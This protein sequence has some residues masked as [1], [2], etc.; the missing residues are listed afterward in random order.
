MISI[1][2]MYLAGKLRLEDLVSDRLRID[3]IILRRATLR[4]ARRPN[5]QWNVKALLPLPALSEKP[6]VLTIDDAT[7][8]VNDTSHEESAAQTV[9]GIALKL[10]PA[11]KEPG[12]ADAE[13]RF[14]VVGSATGLPARELRVE[15]DICTTDGK[16]DLTVKIADLEVSSEL[17]AA[18]P[19][20]LTAELRGAEVSGR[21]DVTLQM[22][23][24]ASNEALNWF[25][26]AK[27]DRGRIAHPMLPVPLTDLV[28][29]CRADARRLLVEHL[30]A[31]CGP[32][33]MVL[34]GE[35][36]TWAKNAPLALAAQFIGLPLN[37]DLRR[38]LPEPCARVWQRFQPA[39]TIDAEIRVTFD[40]RVWRPQLTA[41][42]RA[43]SLTDAEKF[44]YRLEQTTGRVEYLPAQADRA[45]SLRLD[46]T[47][48][49]GGRPVRLAAELSH[50]V[51]SEPEEVSPAQ[52]AKSLGPSHPLG[53][54]EISGSDIPLHEELF[55][56]LSEKRE[57]L[58]RSLQPQG[59]IDFRFRA[60]W[61]E[62][63]QLRAEINQEIRLK[64]C[65]IRYEPFPFPL[66]HVNGLVTQQERRW[67]I[68]DVE[69]RGGN[70][71]TIVK[72]RG[73]STPRGD[74]LHTDLTIE[75]TSVSLDDNL[76]MALSPA[77]QQA[78]DE[79]RPQGRV[80]F[81]ARV[82]HDTD[83]PEPVIE[84]RIQPR[85]RSV[86]IEPTKLPYRLDQI[87]GLA[88]YSA[89]QV[90]L[91]NVSGRHDRAAYSATAGTWKPL[92]DGGWQLALGGVNAD[93]L[94]PRDLLVALPPTLQRT[95]ERMQPGGTF[96]VYNSSL[97][98]IKNR[99]SQ[100][101]AAAWDVNLVCHQATLRGGPPLQN[102]TGE[103]RLV[104]RDDGQTLHTAGE[105]ALDSIVWKD[106]Q[107]TNVRGPLWIDSAVCL[108]GEPASKKQ[109]QSPR[110]ITA[111]AYG[112]SVAANVELQH[113]SAQSYNLD[114]A[115]GGANLA[116]F[117]NERLSGLKD[118]SGTVSGRLAVSGNGQ[119][120][121]SLRGTGDLH[122]VEANIYE[123]PVL[124]AMLKVLKIRAPDTTAFNRCDMQFTID[125]E[126]IHFQQLNLLGDAVSLYGKGESGFDRRLDLTFYTL[127]EP[128][129]LPIPLWK[130]IAGQVSKQTL[131]LKVG[132]T[133]D[134]ADVQPQTLPAV[135][136]VWEQIQTEIQAGAASMAP[137]ATMRD[138]GMTPR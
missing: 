67:T 103:I 6:P 96:A 47:G 82:L 28:C 48:V 112:G 102:M 129:N 77:A 109:S 98:L 93:R 41:D 66:R 92:P 88:T 34:A 58:V 11:K 13:R 22:R 97:S 116:R 8:I 128:A 19:G 94:T 122:V 73:E 25:A 42:C 119:R 131:Q 12:P 4:V 43:V 69:G 100:R 78:W 123:L 118:M 23:R 117:A 7:V 89:G 76:K 5:G 108:L 64:D 52:A 95:M 20:L 54:I 110:R 46:L 111:G 36:A 86:S 31:T 24:S 30:T 133:W 135:N 26:T 72:C 124:V 90:E 38:L 107:L 132:G 80:D 84:A 44:P 113:N 14:R 70:D 75:V 32:G 127:I 56:A 65:T 138:V 71:S 51:R 59:A 99:Q 50:L 33:R 130:T 18:L 121:Q 3:E 57:K 16:M 63:S 134:Q 53:W 79:L 87:D 83:R 120:S 81:N 85:D 21:A 2:E 1:D 114:V 15:G 39:G 10:I 101:A 125:G 49:G 62:L 37:D 68:H 17:I 40:G 27:I 45:D 60:E 137:A 55:A 74:D 115:L 61:K 104:G 91:R 106:V 29:A 105:L 35:R 136:Q 126:N 9:Q